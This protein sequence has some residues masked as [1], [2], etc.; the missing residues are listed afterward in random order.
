MNIMVHMYLECGSLPLSCG[1]SLGVITS[2]WSTWTV[3]PGVGLVA[4]I[5]AGSVLEHHDLHC[6]LA[7]R[8][9]LHLG[10]GQFLIEA[11]SFGNLLPFAHCCSV[12]MS[13]CPRH[14]CRDMRA[15][16]ASVRGAEAC[17]TCILIALSFTRM[18]LLT[19]ELSSLI[20]G[21]V[22]LPSRTT[23]H[24]PLNRL[25]I[26]S[27]VSSSSWPLLYVMVLVMLALSLSAIAVLVSSNWRSMELRNAI[28]FVGGL[29]ASIHR[30]VGGLDLVSTF[31]DSRGRQS[32][33]TC[34]NWCAALIPGLVGSN[35]HL[36]RG[37]WANSL[38]VPMTIPE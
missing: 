27:A 5:P 17:S 8:H 26:E 14:S 4:R 18:S 19:W 38:L 13:A 28:G 10:N 32:F 24:C 16:C 29:G 15:L 7:N 9:P 22:S 34:V 37:W 1:I 2:S 33:Q 31:L 20:S 21:C 12:A 25:G 23:L 11:G 3:L 36:E 6:T 35:G 30:S